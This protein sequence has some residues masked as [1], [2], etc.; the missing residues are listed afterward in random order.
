MRKQ[1][2]CWQLAG[3]DE[4]VKYFSVKSKKYKFK[5]KLLV[6]VVCMHFEV[7]VA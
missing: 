2:Y 1:C 6:V 4:E 5:M 3:T 7:V